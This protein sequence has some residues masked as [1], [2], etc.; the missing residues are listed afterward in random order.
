MNEMSTI[1]KGYADT[2][3][4]QVHYR[5]L[6]LREGTPLILLHQTASSG[7][8]FERLMRLLG[9][10]FPLLAPDTPGF[11]ASFTPPPNFTIAYL[12]NALYAALRQLGVETCFLFGHHTGAALAVQMAFDHPG[13][14]RKL[15]LSGPPLLN[16]AQKNALQASLQ[17]FALAEDGAHLVQAWQRIRGRDPA[18][19]LETVHREVLLTQSAR[20]AAGRAYQ[21]VFEQPFGEQLAALPMPVLVMAGE[22]DTL[23]ACLE[24]AYALLKQG[25]MKVIP[26]QGP[27][28]CDQNPQAVA[29]VIR[30]FL[31]EA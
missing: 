3:D 21:A 2:P 12:A 22:N 29:D 13:F 8:M 19:P 24:P 30:N 27:Y 23:R 17:P 25:A 16:E 11:G 10:S 26:H 20:Q 4:G 31:Q 6:R 5:A 14:A 1:R 7:A 18:L 15:V 28:L 9:D